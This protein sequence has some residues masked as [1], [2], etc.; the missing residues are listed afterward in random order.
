L[1][2]KQ[3]LLPDDHAAMN[4]T[5]NFKV[6]QSM[7]QNQAGCRAWGIYAV[8]LLIYDLAIVW[9]LVASIVMSRK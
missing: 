3:V 2:A 7:G 4:T 9:N 8:K 6:L 1:E 5:W